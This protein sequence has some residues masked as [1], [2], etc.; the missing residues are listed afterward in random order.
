MKTI[1]FGNYQSILIKDCYVRSEQL[2]DDCKHEFLKCDIIGLCVYE[3]ECLTFLIKL[4][5]GEAFSYI[6][7]TSVFWKVPQESEL[8]LEDL[9]YVNS[10]DNKVS[11]SKIE[12]LKVPSS[13]YIKRLDKWFS[14][15]YLYTIDFFRENELLNL[16]ALE[17]GHLA[18]L[19]F[20]K[21]KF[22]EIHLIKKE[23]KKYKKQRL[24]YKI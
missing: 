14:A 4:S 22:K 21:I 10:P 18:F 17:S 19:P 5:D 7:P 11:I 1:E 24:T 3:N 12:H 2:I 20:H 6:P 8:V 15:E 23:F 13:C 9:C 16:L